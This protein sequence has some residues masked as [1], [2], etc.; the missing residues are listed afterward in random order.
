[1]KYLKCPIEITFLAWVFLLPFVII[2]IALFSLIIDGVPLETLIEI[3]GYS[4]MIFTGDAII[5]L[6]SSFHF[7]VDLAG[8]LISI[9]TCIGVLNAKPWARFVFVFCYGLAFFHYYLMFGIE[10]LKPSGFVFYL[11]IIFILF[12]PRAN[13]YFSAINNLE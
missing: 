2:L 7:I 13:K 11:V 9:A 12:S 6:P 5:E 1:M 3:H 10:I 4:S 8:M